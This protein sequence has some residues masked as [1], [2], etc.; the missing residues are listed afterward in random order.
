MHFERCVKELIGLR[1][2]EVELTETAL[3]LSFD[4][5]RKVCFRD[6]GQDCCEE[7]FMTCDDEISLLEDHRL[8][9]VVLKDGPNIPDGEEH[10]IQFLEIQTDA[11]FVTITN[12]NRHNG[13]YGGFSL[14]CDLVIK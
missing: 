5:G 10:E 13:Y 6:G 9:G 7:R 11:G 12:H 3:Y 14:V 2:I 1:I 8:L 4:N